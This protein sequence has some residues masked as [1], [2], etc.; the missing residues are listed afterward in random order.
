[1]R[2]V[3]VSLVALLTA[4]AFPVD[5]FTVESEAGKDK[6]AAK[7]SADA[8]ACLQWDDREPTKCKKWSDDECKEEK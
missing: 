5:D 8:C 2:M 1:M 3:V 6:P 4:C 7:S